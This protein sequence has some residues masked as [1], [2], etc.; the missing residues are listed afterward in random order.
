MNDEGQSTIFQHTHND[1]WVQV[2][3]IIRPDMDTDI[4]L[5]TVAS[6][7]FQVVI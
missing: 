2:I 6:Q 1:K 7:C 5:F 4:Q 3:A